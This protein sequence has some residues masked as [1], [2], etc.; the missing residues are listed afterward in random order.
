MATRRW[1][2]FGA[3]AAAGVATLI[4]LF[5]L[6]IGLYNFDISGTDDICEGTLADPCV[7]YISVKNPNLYHV[8][9]Y[10]PEA[11]RLAFSPQIKEYYLFRKDGRCYGGASCAAPN[12]LSI[13]GW[14]YIDF[15]NAT[16]P[17]KDKVYVFRF[18]ARETK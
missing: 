15:T 18:P 1:L 7:S 5:S 17:V 6:L 4:G 16:K 9:I 11:I 10:N 13:K 14:N 2:K 12:G 8:D 3:G